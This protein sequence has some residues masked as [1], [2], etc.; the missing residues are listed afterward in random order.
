[1]AL[2]ASKKFPILLSKGAEAI[3]VLIDKETRPDCTGE[4][5]QAV[6]KEALARLKDLSSTLDL[7][8]VFK[9][10]MFENWLVADIAA[11][12]GLPGLFQNVERIEK[13]VSNGRADTVK[14]LDLLK[15][16]SKRSYDKVD[17]AVAICKGLDPILAAGNS[18]S[19]RKLLKVLEC[20]QG[21]PVLD[22]EAPRGCRQDRGGPPGTVATRPWRNFDCQRTPPRAGIP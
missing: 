14:A 10:F 3:V 8:V 18:R 19:F 5:A 20:R 21:K 6:E 9:V 11:L 2:A 15:A 17:G 12:R 7:R 16:C 4:L 13:R 22:L 1:M